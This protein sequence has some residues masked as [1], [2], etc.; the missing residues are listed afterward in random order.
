M[1]HRSVTAISPGWLNRGDGIQIEID[2]VLKRRR[3]GT[4]MQVFRQGYEPG[5]TFGLNRDHFG[6]SIIG[7]EAGLA[8]GIGQRG[9]APR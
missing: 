9:V 6:Q 1:A 5:G 4:V 3:G 7:A 8:F 2:H